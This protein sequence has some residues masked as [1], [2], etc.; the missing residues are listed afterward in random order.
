[1]TSHSSQLYHKFDSVMVLSHGRSLYSGPGGFAPATYFS[2]ATGGGV[3]AYQQGYNVA[4]Y[5]LDVASDPP[6]S[7]FQSHPSYTASTVEVAERDSTGDEKPRAAKAMVSSESLKQAS[8]GRTTYSTT[9]LT[10]L[11]Y[12]CGREWKILK[13]DRSLFV[14]HVVAAA[15]LGVFCGTL[16]S[17]LRG[18]SL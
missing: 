15:L 17:F 5:L 6:V 11:Q 8:S 14:T 3:P 9:F 4:E 10:Q 12:L 1:M 18:G 13:R 16:S 2:N 7:L